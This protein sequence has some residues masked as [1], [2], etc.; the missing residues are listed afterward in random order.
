MSEDLI[1]EGIKV[2]DVGSWIAAPSCATMLA[3][4]GADVIKIE[5]P[6]TG[7][8]YRGYYD[9]P[10]SPNSEVNYTWILDNRNK[11]SLSL[12]LKSEQGLAI[13]KKL[14]ED[15]DIY[16]TNMPLPF[17]RSQGLMWEDLAPLNQRMLV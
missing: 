6:E 14:V 15:V 8:A 16:V 13:L 9:M 3:D 10:P 11:R 1:L 4:R 7:D 12:N 17:R 2:L 5:P